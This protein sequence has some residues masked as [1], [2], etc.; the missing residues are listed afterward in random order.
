MSDPPLVFLNTKPAPIPG[1]G[2][3][4][5]TAALLYGPIDIL[6]PSTTIEPSWYTPPVIEMASPETAQESTAALIVGAI[7]GTYQVFPSTDPR[8]EARI[9]V[10]TSN[11]LS[12]GITSLA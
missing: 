1:D 10:A 12:T 4:T 7:D 3:I 8:T 2:A 5:V 6:F 9:N 11:I